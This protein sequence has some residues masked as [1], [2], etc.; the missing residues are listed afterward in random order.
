MLFV[1]AGQLLSIY[2]C[3]SFNSWSALFTDTG[4]FLFCE[5]I[6]LDNKFLGW[7][8]AFVNNG[9]FFVNDVLFKVLNFGAEMNHTS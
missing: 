9:L 7:I 4:N 2:E 8:F 6:L 1:A 5:T 3:L